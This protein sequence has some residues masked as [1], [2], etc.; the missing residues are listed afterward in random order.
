MTKVNREELLFEIP[1]TEMAGTGD[2]IVQLDPGVVRELVEANKDDDPQFPV[3]RVEEGLSGNK[4]LWTRGV[5]QDVAEQVNRENPVGYMGHIK[6]EDERWAFPEI[7]TKWLKAQMTVEPSTQSERKGNMVH[8][9]YVKGYNLPKTRVRSYVAAK[10]NLMTSWRGKA[11]CEVLKGGVRKPV[12]F[13]MESIDW[14]RPGKGAMEARLVTVA[15]ESK[16]GV[17]KVEANEIAALSFAELKQHNPNLV[18]LILRDGRDESTEKISEM[19]KEVEEG[20]EAKSLIDKLRELL[21]IEENGD[22]LQTVTDIVHR[23]EKAGRDEI[24]S[25]LDTVLGRK[26]KNDK[27]RETIKRLLPV[28]EMVDEFTGKEKGELEK[29]VEE[30]VNEAF[31][32]D[33]GIKI[34]ASASSAPAPLAHRVAEQ[35]NDDG[36]ENQP[37]GFKREKVRL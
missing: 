31:D 23:V 18:E 19:E 3:I 32:A 16:E 7:Q 21:K 13:V 2:A 27:S 4:M 25:A 24:V 28:S 29:L 6:P 1:V 17:E 33:E 12:K 22:V 15:A 37:T 26:V 14:S 36:N 8:T 9:L 34:L 5:M 30:K 11:D 10:I 35:K 20:K